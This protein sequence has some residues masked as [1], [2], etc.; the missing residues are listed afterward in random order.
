MNKNKKVLGF[1]KDK[2]KKWFL[3][4]T[5]LTTGFLVLVFLITITLIG[6]DVK[7]RCLTA[8][9]KYEGDCVEALIQTVDGDINS[10]KERNYA[11]WALGIIGDERA[12][13]V[14]EKY[15]TGEIPDREPY[16]QTLSQYEM[17]KALK[18]LGKFNPN[19]L[20]WNVD[21]F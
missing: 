7:E 21:N 20:F 10:L 6:I 5:T 11:I 9:G 12:R 18:L 8:Q 19:H 3:Y 13:P 14:I 16:D 15:Y 2:L 1:D 4:W 17:K